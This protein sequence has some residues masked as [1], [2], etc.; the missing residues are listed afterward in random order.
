LPED[1]PSDPHARSLILHFR[2]DSV[3]PAVHR[4]VGW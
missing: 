2:K 4:G 1:R 3:N